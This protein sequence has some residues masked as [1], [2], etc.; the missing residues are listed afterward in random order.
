MYPRL[1]G[2]VTNISM[3]VIGGQNGT[4]LYCLLC[5]IGA[6]SKGNTDIS[7]I[8]QRHLVNRQT[9]ANINTLL[10]CS[11]GDPKY[12]RVTLKILSYFTLSKDIKMFH[13]SRT[14]NCIKQSSNALS[15]ALTCHPIEKESLKV[16]KF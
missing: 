4:I 13:Y 2:A 1:S 10:L 7:K 14:G 9:Q 8:C 16:R 15:T 6:F 3:L 12:S 5:P 11:E